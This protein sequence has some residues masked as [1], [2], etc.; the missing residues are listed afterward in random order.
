MEGLQERW[1]RESGQSTFEGM[2]F[3]GRWRRDRMTEVRGGKDC[4]TKEG[5]TLRGL[6]K[7]VW[8]LWLQAETWWRCRPVLQERHWGARLRWG[9]GACRSGALQGENRCL[10][11]SQW[12]PG[13][14]APTSCVTGK[15]RFC[16]GWVQVPL[17]CHVI[18]CY[19]RHSSS[20]PKVQILVSDVIIGKCFCLAK[21]TTL[22]EQSDKGLFISL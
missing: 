8:G 21:I 4:W 18:F 17:L 16:D 12:S 13:P 22:N 19:E 11:Q 10:S 9:L 1:K 20:F 14:S 3:S 5:L 2:G 6:G 15:V 7:R